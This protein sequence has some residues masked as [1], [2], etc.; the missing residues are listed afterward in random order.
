MFELS[1]P[2]ADVIVVTEVPDEL[3]LVDRGR[4][5]RSAINAVAAQHALGKPVRFPGAYAR[6]V[7]ELGVEAW[8]PE[9]SWTW[10]LGHSDE[11]QRLERLSP[12]TSM[13]DLEALMPLLL[14]G[15]VLAD[16]RL[17]VWTRDVLGHAIGEH[18]I[19]CDACRHAR[20]ASWYPLLRQLGVQPR[21]LANY[22]SSL[23]TQR[24][25]DRRLAVVPK[26]EDDGDFVDF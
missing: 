22:W 12:D 10:G 4:L 2:A 18:E 9:T 25:A 1:F 17:P 6:R 15:H 13:P 23:S 8:Q 26:A 14:D 16:P 19:E 7:V 11:E 24:L 5:V 20:D 3:S 21:S